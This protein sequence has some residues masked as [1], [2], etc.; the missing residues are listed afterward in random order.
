[1]KNRFFPAVLL[2]GCMSTLLA[3]P[4]LQPTA[5][6][7]A[8]MQKTAV[9]EGVW[10]G[11]GWIQLGPQRSTF[12]I[13]EQ[14]AFKANRSVFIMEGIGRDA[15]D[16]TQ[17]VHQAFAVI[18]F[19]EQASRYRM[20]AFRGD[21]NS[22]D[23]DFNVQDDGSIVWGFTHPM[24]GQVRY[25]IRLAGGQWVETGEMSRDGQNWRPFFEMTLERQ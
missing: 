18:S 3:Q 9:L 5:A 22:V 21:G 10:K 13:V 8:A 2:W 6:L 16:S 4:G 1:M 24:A 20:R 14:G 17:I 15:N 12:N 7:A 19:D 25:T 23:A 11:S